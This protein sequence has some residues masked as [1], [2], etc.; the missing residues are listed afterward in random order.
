VSSFAVAL[1][2]I[3]AL[4]VVNVWVIRRDR[5]T[6][7]RPDGAEN[8]AEEFSRY[9]FSD[10]FRRM[11][12]ATKL[13]LAG[14]LV[15][16]VVYSQVAVAAAAGMVLLMTGAVAAH[17]KVRDPLVKSVPALLMLAMSAT[18]VLVRI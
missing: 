3:I 6:G 1:Q 17:I 16:G 10:S 15:V 8:I 18:V 5:A 12:G 11:I 9:G 4:G 14:L 7:Y 2:L 13:L